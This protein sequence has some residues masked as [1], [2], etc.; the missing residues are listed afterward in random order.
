MKLKKDPMSL[1][2]VAVAIVAI[3]TAAKILIETFKH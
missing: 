2:T 3:L 1:I